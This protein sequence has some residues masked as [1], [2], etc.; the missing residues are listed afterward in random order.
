M[1][2]YVPDT[3]VI[4]KI[5]SEDS[6]IDKVLAG[7]YG[8]YLNGDSWKLNSG[9]TKIV[10]HENFY[11]IHGHSGSVYKCYKAEQ[12]LSSTMQS[13]L[14]KFKQLEGL[15]VEVMNIKAVLERYQG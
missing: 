2:E 15:T 11:D 9:I 10:E 6:E 5:K 14:L 1:T 13:I 3:W 12:Y 7:W 4:L 8:G